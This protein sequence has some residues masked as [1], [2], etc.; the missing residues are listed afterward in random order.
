MA[1][2]QGEAVVLRV[3]EFGESDR[4]VHLL[5]PEWGRVTAIAKGA[6]RSRKR[7][8]GTLDLFHRLRVQIERRRPTSMA[9]LDHTRLLDSFGAIRADPVRF[10]IAAYLAELLDRLATEGGRAG[11]AAAVYRAAVATFH[12]LTRLPADARTLVLLELRLLAVLGLQPELRHCVR[13]GD[14]IEREPRVRFHIGEGGPLCPG[15]G[16]EAATAMPVQLGTLRALEHSLSFSLE[17]LDRLGRIG[18]GTETLAEARAL[19]HR[20]Q[21][22]HVGIELRSERVVASLLQWRTRDTRQSRPA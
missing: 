22:F 18:L 11:D 2:L 5:T 7:F 3:V 15:C 9:R 12:A 13:C 21:R 16:S 8:A 10:A 4:I 17:H 19:V 6:R 14:P 1:S 20:F